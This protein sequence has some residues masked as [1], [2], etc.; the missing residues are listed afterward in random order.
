M[1]LTAQPTLVDGLHPEDEMLG[2]AKT[3]SRPSAERA[4]V[5]ALPLTNGA[6]AREPETPGDVS[7]RRNDTALQLMSRL[8]ADA[9]SLLFFPDNRLDTAPMHDLADANHQQVVGGALRAALAAGT[10]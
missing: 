9:P 8:G 5:A 10:A 1:L 2:C 6:D 7:S 3:I 4:G